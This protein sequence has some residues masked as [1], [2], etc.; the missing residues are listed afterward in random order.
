VVR[1]AALQLQVQV[2]EYQKVV[3]D[4]IQSQTTFYHDQ[5]A[6]IEQ[7]RQAA[8]EEA[9]ES[10]HRSSASEIATKLSI[11]PRE[12]ARLAVVTDHLIATTD[13]EYQL[14]QQLYA[15]EE[16]ANAQTEASISKLQ[17]QKDLLETVKT[18]L[19]QLSTAPKRRA[20]ALLSIS[21]DI[22]NQIQG[23]K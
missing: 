10:F 15:A 19:D 21:E 7:S 9:I 12:T 14:Y 2:S 22:F 8:L 5:I 11:A 6:R 23:G 16:A 20:Q 13:A 3:D 18:N 17:R 4:K 1:R